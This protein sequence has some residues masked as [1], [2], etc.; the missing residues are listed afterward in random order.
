MGNGVLTFF[1][2]HGAQEDD[3]ARAI[4]AGLAVID[5]VRGLRP[6]PDLQLQ[7]RIGIATGQVV[8]GELIGAGEARERS[9][10][11]ETPNLAARLQALAEPDAVV[12][13]R[14]TRRLVGSLF[15]LADLGTHELKGFAKPVS[16]WRVLGEGRAEGRF[17]AMRAAT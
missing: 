12:I 8:V 11:G 16:A 9:V 1:G 5:A 3:P 10:V 13:G 15:E 7:V 17:E 4:R 2:W 14:R 6:Q